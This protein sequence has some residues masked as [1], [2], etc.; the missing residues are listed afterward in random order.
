[1]HRT[2]IYNCHMQATVVIGNNIAKSG[3]I[4]QLSERSSKSVDLYINNQQNAQLQDKHL[5]FRTLNVN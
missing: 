2:N 5:S 1:M 4:V 3:S